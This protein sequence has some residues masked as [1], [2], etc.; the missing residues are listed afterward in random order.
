MRLPRSLT[1]AV[2]LAVVSA[3]AL[4]ACAPE[5]TDDAGTAEDTAATESA[6]GATDEFPVT[7]THALGETVIESA[8]ERVATWGW[9]ST[10]AAL[11]V[12]VEPIG[13]SEQI[14]TVG[15]QALLPWVEEEYDALGAEHPVIFTDAEGGA[16]VPYE[17][18]VEADPDLILAP[19]SGLTQEQYDVLSDIAPVVAYPESPW[20]TPWDEI[21]TITAQAL[22]RSEA[23]EQ[24]LADIDT[25]L[26]D[27]AAEI[28]EAEG[29]TFAAIVDSPSEGLVYVYTPAD[30]R[31]AVL[32]NLGIASAPSVAELD[33]SD[34]GFFYTLSY[35]ELDKLESDF[36]IAYTY[37][38][39]EA[40]T[41]G[42]SDELQAI[43]AVAAGDVVKVVGNVAV[44][45]VSP[46]TALS[47][48]WPDGVPAIAD[49]LAAI[50]GG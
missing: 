5:T 38:E 23:G 17:E 34:G 32:E 22:G 20:V 6:D 41:F 42:E 14:F 35:E 33:T 40:A 16:S 9:G 24:V 3:L 7:I 50:Y 29:K 27:L 28:P 44:S 4:T 19:Y 47:Y 15:E 12:G 36:V 48:D 37:T 1:T 39:E 25:Y 18:F 46:P 10:E 11:A 13:V 31:V 8:P 30:P 21:V 43:P 49:Q 2:G 26:T 45:S